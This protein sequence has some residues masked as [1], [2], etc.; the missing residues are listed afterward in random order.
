MSMGTVHVLDE[1]VEVNLLD[2]RMEQSICIV[3]YCMFV[4]NWWSIVNF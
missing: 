4:V 1:G 2:Q 3:N